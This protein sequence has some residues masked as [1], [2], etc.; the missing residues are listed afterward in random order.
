MHF[1]LDNVHRHSGLQR[2]RKMALEAFAHTAEPDYRNMAPECCFYSA[3]LILTYSHRGIKSSSTLHFL[4]Q[5]A[6][7][8]SL[9]AL[10]MWI[11]EIMIA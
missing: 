8:A 10:S 9:S 2:M 3:P 7:N 4:T 6:C 1:H 5:S 11:F